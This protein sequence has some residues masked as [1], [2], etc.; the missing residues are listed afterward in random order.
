MFRGSGYEGVGFGVV[1]VML[2]LNWCH[3][4]VGC[5]LKG[6]LEEKASNVGFRV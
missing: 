4:A 2:L 1:G 5:S 6:P 3:V